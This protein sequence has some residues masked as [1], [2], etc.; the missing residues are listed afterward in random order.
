M[1]KLGIFL[2][3]LLFTLCN[4][5][6]SK[7]SSKESSGEDSGLAI[8][9]TYGDVYFPVFE[10]I[11]T[12]TLK[13][14]PGITLPN[15]TITTANACV[16]QKGEEKVEIFYAVAKIVRY[17]PT[18]L[19]DLFPNLF[20]IRLDN[21]QLKYIT[22]KDLQQFGAKLRMFVSYLNQIEFLERDLFIY[23]EEL[24][25]VN[26]RLNKITYIDSKVF[27]V[28]I[29]KRLTNLWLDGTSITCGFRGA[30]SRSACIKQVELLQS[31]TN[32]CNKLANAP[33]FYI[34]WLQQEDKETEECVCETTTQGGEA[35]TTTIQSNQADCT[36]QL[37]DAQA[38]AQAEC[39]GRLDESITMCEEMILCANN[40]GGADCP[41][42][43][44]LLSTFLKNVLG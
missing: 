2:S 25:Y 20:G 33:P 38:N 26:F 12:C 30:A 9:C 6:G 19:L 5:K 42:S 37:A 15:T 11:N 36:N 4:G 44:K 13:T 28:L 24:E 23:N 22:K 18:G 40:P 29:S 10:S 1:A 41:T 31:E 3:L 43:D 14:N 35:E 34:F 32:Q 17:I 39:D 7:E 27:D 21:T 16:K 8:E